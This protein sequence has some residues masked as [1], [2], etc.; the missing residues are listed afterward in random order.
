M[1][2][3]LNALFAGL[4][5]AGI[6]SSAMAESALEKALA[7]GA[8]RLTSEQIADRFFGKTV[9]FVASKSGDKYL[10]YYGPDNKIIGGKMGSPK[11]GSGF[12]AVNDRDQI[13]LG[14]K[15]K[16]LPRIRCIDIVLIDGVV[17]KYRADG[18]LSGTVTQ[19]NEGN[20]T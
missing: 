13:C 4:A 2:K 12:V 9:T 20:S 1:S 7:N 10:L 3:T 8:V 18:S 5:F 11:R 6:A 19:F 14:W 15:G 17:H 16:D